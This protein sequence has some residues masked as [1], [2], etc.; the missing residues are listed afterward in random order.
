MRAAE[1][2]MGETEDGNDHGERDESEVG[3]KCGR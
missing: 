2:G 1:M 3:R